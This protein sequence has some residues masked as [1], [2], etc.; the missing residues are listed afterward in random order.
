MPKSTPSV[1][2]RS[3]RCDC[4][5]QHTFPYLQ[6]CQVWCCRS[7]SRNPE[8]NY[9]P[10]LPKLWLPTRHAHPTTHPRTNVS[11]LSP[12]PM[13]ATDCADCGTFVSL[14]TAHMYV[15]PSGHRSRLLCDSCVPYYRDS[16]VYRPAQLPETSTTPSDEDERLARSRTHTHTRP[17][18]TGAHPRQGG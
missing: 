15:S 17:R 4:T 9:E 2:C 14:T 11:E 13:S 3:C 18:E 6:V 1:G 10:I 7:D 16:N 5:G 8:S 12:R